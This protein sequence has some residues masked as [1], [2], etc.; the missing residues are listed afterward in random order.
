MSDVAGL[1]GQAAASLA[2]PLVRNIGGTLVA[3]LV[4]RRGDL[5]GLRGG[6]RDQELSKFNGLE[7]LE[8]YK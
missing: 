3:G 5:A 8:D 6:E 4:R 2:R 7:R 1:C